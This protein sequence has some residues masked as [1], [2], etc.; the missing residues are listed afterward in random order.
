MS[1]NISIEHWLTSYLLLIYANSSCFSNLSRNNL[2]YKYWSYTHMHTQTHVSIHQ[3]NKQFI[4]AQIY[5]SI[6]NELIHVCSFSHCYWCHS[7]FVNKEGDFEFIS[8][9]VPFWMRALVLSNKTFLSCRL[10]QHTLHSHFRCMIIF[11]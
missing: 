11:Y 9:H 10:L 7:I 5:I 4:L 1:T 6:C 8:Y 3:W 2:V